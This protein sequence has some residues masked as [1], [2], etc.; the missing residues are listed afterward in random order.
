M[1]ASGFWKRFLDN[2]A[3]PRG[4][5]LPDDLQLTDRLETLAGCRLFAGEGQLNR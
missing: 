1:L 5:A 2:V 3:D 4:F